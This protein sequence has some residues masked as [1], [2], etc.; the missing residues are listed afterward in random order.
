M[1]A[2]VSAFIST[3]EKPS[4]YPNLNPPDYNFYV[5]LKSIKFSKRHNYLEFLKLSLKKILEEFPMKLARDL[6]DDWESTLRG[7]IKNRGGIF[8][9]FLVYCNIRLF[10][11]LIKFISCR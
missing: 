6:I 3:S 7:F 10:V 11:V 8:E 2:S 5:N 4:E 1:T 9:F